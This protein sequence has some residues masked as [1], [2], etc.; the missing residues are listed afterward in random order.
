M[1]ARPGLVEA[2]FACAGVL[3]AR[4]GSADRERARELL[5]LARLGAEELEMTRLVE[6]AD[7]LLA[8]SEALSASRR[9]LRSL[10]HGLSERELDVLRLIVAGNSD[11]EIAETLYISKRT[12]TT[13]V[14]NI[15]NKLGLNTRAEAAAFAVRNGLV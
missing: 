5:N 2:Q 7:A 11:R 12:V 8:S 1:Q 6:Q 4:A 9:T 15:F 3:L 13:H 10:P 14:S